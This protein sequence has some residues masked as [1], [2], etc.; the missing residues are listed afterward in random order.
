MQSF[1]ILPVIPLITVVGCAQNDTGR[2]F[3]EQKACD[4]RIGQTTRRDDALV[5]GPFTVGGA[6]HGVSLQIMVHRDMVDDSPLTNTETTT[7]MP[8]AAQAPLGRQARTG[9]VTTASAAGR[10]LDT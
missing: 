8:S 7:T 5:A 10:R 6:G 3:D 2:P 4:I 1:S 9:E